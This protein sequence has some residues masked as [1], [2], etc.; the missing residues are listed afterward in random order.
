[1]SNSNRKK[2][3]IKE[4]DCLK[5]LIK[6]YSENNWKNISIGMIEKN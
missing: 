3:L 5:N 4:D 2:W 6:K 1:M